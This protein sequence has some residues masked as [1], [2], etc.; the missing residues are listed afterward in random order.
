MPARGT[1]LVDQIRTALEK[2]TAAN[3]YH[4]DAGLRVTRGRPENLQVEKAQLPVITVSTSSSTPGAAK[5]STVIKSREV[6]V[7]GLVD[8]DERDYEPELDQ[9]DED[10]TMAL[11]QMLGIDALPNTTNVSISGGDY[12]HPESGSNTAGVTHTIT[13]SYP[14]TKTEG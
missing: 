1:E 9:L 13:I 11:A 2:V 4:T 12:I 7:T 10:I 5:P 3:G 8:A 14:L 6:L